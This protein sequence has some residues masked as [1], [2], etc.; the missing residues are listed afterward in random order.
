MVICTDTKLSY[1][2]R[3][4]NHLASGWENSHYILSPVIW[5]QSD[6]KSINRLKIDSF[7]EQYHN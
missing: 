6:K 1:V 7:K 5:L 3:L 4:L 2:E